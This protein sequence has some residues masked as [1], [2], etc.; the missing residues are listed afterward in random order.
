MFILYI[1]IDIQFIIYTALTLSYLNLIFDFTVIYSIPLPVG[2]II[3]Y[4]ESRNSPFSG[5]IFDYINHSVNLHQ[6]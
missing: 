2:F 5:K 6:F 4:F 1:I 3:I